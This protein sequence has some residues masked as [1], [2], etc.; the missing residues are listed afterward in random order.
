MQ[1]ALNIVNVALI[2]VLV[3]AA[4]T[5]HVQGGYAPAE[6]SFTTTP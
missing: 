3:V 2:A 6:V 1:N 5:V 4:V